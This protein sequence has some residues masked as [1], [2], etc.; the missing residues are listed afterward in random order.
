M[1]ILVK[2]DQSDIMSQSHTF[3]IM[4]QHGHAETS[5]AHY[6]KSVYPDA[7]LGRAEESGG[8]PGGQRVLRR[9]YISRL[10]E[11]RLLLV[12]WLGCHSN[13]FNISRIV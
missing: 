10:P 7:D 4:R 9:D 2:L 8:P 12:I 5:Q 11:N 1:E 3:R 13:S 6:S